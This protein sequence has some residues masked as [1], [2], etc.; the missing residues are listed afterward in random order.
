MFEQYAFI[1]CRNNIHNISCFAIRKERHIII[2]NKCQ[3][4]QILMMKVDLQYH[5]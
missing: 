3:N 4:I 5:V 2:F 1:E